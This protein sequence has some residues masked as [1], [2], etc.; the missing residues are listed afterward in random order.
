[1]YVRAAVQK[2]LRKSGCGLLACW[3]FVCWC[4]VGERAVA[5]RAFE[6]EGVYR[7]EFLT[8]EHRNTAGPEHRFIMRVDSPR[9]V[10][11]V[12]LLSELPVP[13]GFSRCVVGCDGTD[14]YVTR[15]SKPEDLSPSPGQDTNSVEWLASLERARRGLSPQWGEVFPGRV[16]SWMFWHIHLLWLAFCGGEYFVDGQPAPIGIK[17]FVL[18]P[19]DPTEPVDL[20]WSSHAEDRSVLQ[21]LARIH[22]GRGSRGPGKAPFIY[23]PPFDKGFTNTFYEVI[24]AGRVGGIVV[25]RKFQCTDFQARIDPA[26][27]GPMA[28]A[29]IVFDAGRIGPLRQRITGRPALGA[30]YQVTDHRAAPMNDGKPLVYRTHREWWQT[31]E[32]RFVKALQGI[33]EEEKPPQLSR[34][35]VWAAFGLLVVLYGVGYWVWRLRRQ[36]QAGSVPGGG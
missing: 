25:P 26:T 34:W 9:W 23:P 31:N 7:Y 35:T 14:I 11:E 19:Y 28:T 10:C 8:P 22:P 13:A 29:R 21:W 18:N 17:F 5:G 36:R 2:R 16:P 24:E 4:F 32:A 1:V 12:E 27:G 15:L 3:G 30:L 6:A 33:F 20:R